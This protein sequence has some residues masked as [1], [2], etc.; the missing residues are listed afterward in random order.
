MAILEF[1]AIWFV[2]GSV[3]SVLF[4][5]AIYCMG[6]DAPKANGRSRSRQEFKF[7]QAQSLGASESSGKSVIFPFL[8]QNT[9]SIKP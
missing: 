1:I 2:I 4:G 7:A 6:H 5:T 3:V 8:V 9:R